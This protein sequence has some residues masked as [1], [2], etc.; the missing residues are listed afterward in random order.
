MSLI[1][2]IKTRRIEDILN[3]GLRLGLVGTVNAGAD[4]VVMAGGQ[5]RNIIVTGWSLSTSSATDVL[6]SLG[7]KVAGQP[8]ASFAAG[9]VKSGSSLVMIYPLG[10]E[11]Y[12]ESAASLVITTNG[13]PVAY[14]VNGR[15]IS[16]KVGLGYIERT[17]ISGMP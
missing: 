14:T 13:G 15:L 16:E 4:T 3:Q 6:V 17:A 9:Y 11:R 2:T 12:G 10:D 7:F 8:T 5:E 1:Y